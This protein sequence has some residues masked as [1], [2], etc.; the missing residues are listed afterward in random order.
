M[1]LFG[2]ILKQDDAVSAATIPPDIYEGVRVMRDDVNELQGKP[3]ERVPGSPVAEGADSGH[4]FLGSHKSPSAPPHDSSD[5]IS[6]KNSKKWLIPASIALVVLIIGGVAAYFFLRPVPAEVMEEPLS[7]DASSMTDATQTP[8]GEPV[9][10][11]IAVFST[12][13]PNYLALDPESDMATPEG[14]VAKLAETGAKV[15]EM[16]PSEPVEFLLRDG[17]NNPIAF[18]RFSYLMKL[19]IPEETIALI[20]EAFSIYFVVEG[21]DIRMAVALDAKEGEQL[22]ASV[23]QSESALP[24]WFGGLLYGGMTIPP[25]DAVQFRSGAY[26]AIET[27]FASIDAGRNRSF[28]YAFLSGKWVIGT[29]KDSFRSTLDAVLRGGLK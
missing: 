14:I 10:V 25:A 16:N 17:N 3:S 20:D 24:S 27:R 13:S 21:S 1:G 22:A 4:P 5:A 6:S 11:P 19:G 12:D 28:D 15:R 9:P 7:T 23:K 29:S 2:K 18:S 8:I 26:G